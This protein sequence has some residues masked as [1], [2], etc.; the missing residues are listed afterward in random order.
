MARLGAAAVQRDPPRRWRWARAHPAAEIRV[1]DF[2][3]RRRRSESPEGREAL[4]DAHR[5][6]PVPRGGA[7]CVGPGGGGA[8]V[9]EGAIARLHRKS[10]ALA[11]QG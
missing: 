6:D 3:R 4:D 8:H 9:G 1:E 2:T 5:A 7:G 11:G 10:A